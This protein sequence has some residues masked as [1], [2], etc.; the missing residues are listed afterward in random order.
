[1][2]DQFGLPEHLNQW[3]LKFSLNVCIYKWQSFNL[4]LR[5]EIRPRTFRH[6]DVK[7]SL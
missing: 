7:D 2:S 4:L 6:L 1:M 5:N 3:N